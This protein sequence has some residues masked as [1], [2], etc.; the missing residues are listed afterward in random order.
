MKYPELSCNVYAEVDGENVLLIEIDRE[1]RAKVYHENLRIDG[2]RKIFEE[3]NCN[4]ESRKYIVNNSPQTRTKQEPRYPIASSTYTGNKRRVHVTV[5]YI[6]EIVRNT[7]GEWVG[8]QIL[9]LESTSYKRVLGRYKRY[10]TVHSVDVL[11][12]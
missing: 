9:Q 2:V 7:N 10:K 12:F 11:G 4:I 8:K 1:G 5:L 6:R 3:I